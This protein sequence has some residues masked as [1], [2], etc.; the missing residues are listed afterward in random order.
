MFEYIVIYKCNVVYWCMICM[1]IHSLTHTMIW[2]YDALLHSMMYIDT[3]VWWRFFMHYDVYLKHTPYIVDDYYTYSMMIVHT[4]WWSYILDDDFSYLMII[5]HIGW[6]WFILDGVDAHLWWSKK[7]RIV[8]PLIVYD[9]VYKNVHNQCVAV[10]YIG[11]I[12]QWSECRCYLQR[13]QGLICDRS[14]G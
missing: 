11:M 9:D 4:W 7:K 3:M 1:M 10:T 5:V 14:T 8:W 12:W 6:W 13:V 2:F